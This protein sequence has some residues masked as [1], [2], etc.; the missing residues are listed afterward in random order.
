MRMILSAEVD[1]E[2]VGEADCGE[3]AL[4]QTGVSSRTSSVR[5]HLPGVSGLEV[6]ERIVK[7]DY[8]P[9]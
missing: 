5:P 7:G 1:I 2:V 6:N 3:E 9:R 4:P 8:G